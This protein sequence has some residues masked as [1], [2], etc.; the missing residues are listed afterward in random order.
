MLDNEVCYRCHCSKLTHC[1]HNITKKISQSRRNP[2]DVQSTSPDQNIYT[3]YKTLVSNQAVTKDDPYTLYRLKP[4]T[5]ST[6]HTQFY[7][8]LTRRTLF[9]AAHLQAISHAKSHR[10]IVQRNIV[11]GLN[12][13]FSVNAPLKDDICRPIRIPLTVIQ[14]T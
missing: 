14:Q 10:T 9:D 6:T 5:V 2:K 12:S 13:F 4:P 11:Q 1:V 7:H 8:T 3:I